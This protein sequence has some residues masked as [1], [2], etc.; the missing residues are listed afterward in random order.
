MREYTDAEGRVWLVWDVPPRFRPRRSGVERRQ[1]VISDFTP[2][3][4]SRRDRRKVSAP[5]EWVHGW[6]CFES[7]GKREKRRL[8][9]LPE[10]WEACGT[11]Q[12]EEYL[13]RATPIR[14]QRRAAAD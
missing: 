4:R 7:S 10:D 9:P 11:E 3:R 1:T 12:L 13:S 8:C 14:R 5:P 6:L 2:E